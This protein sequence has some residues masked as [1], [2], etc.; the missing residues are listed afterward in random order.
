VEGSP[1]ARREGT[2]VA[3]LLGGEVL[4]LRA[5]E[6]PRY[7]AGA[8]LLGGGLVVLF[9]VAERMLERALGDRERARRALASLAAS[10]VDN[11]TLL[12]PARALTGP[13]ARGDAER[14]AGHLRE[15]ADLS[16][17]AATLYRELARSM[18]LLARSRG[19]LGPAERRRVERALGPRSRR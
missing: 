10:V 17:A 6:K 13:A 18:L 8:A 14:I 12:G 5:A 7:H 19:T 16:P 11:I 4:V 3:R 9:D 1:A 15:L 2:R